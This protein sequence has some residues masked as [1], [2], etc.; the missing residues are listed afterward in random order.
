[1]SFF[2]FLADKDNHQQV[3]TDKDG[4]SRLRAITCESKNWQPCLFML[5]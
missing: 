4:W 3:I 1:M 5:N 2:F